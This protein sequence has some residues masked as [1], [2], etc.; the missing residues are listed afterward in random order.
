MRLSPPWRLSVQTDRHDLSTHTIYVAAATLSARLQSYFCPDRGKTNI[1]TGLPTLGLGTAKKN[2]KWPTPIS[3][4]SC[5][6]VTS[7]PPVQTQR[8]FLSKMLKLSNKRVRPLFDNE[9]YLFVDENVSF[10]LVCIKMYAEYSYSL[11]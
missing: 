10:L 11:E 8:W 4:R 2:T 5:R 7:A 3:A 9:T 1:N 6:D